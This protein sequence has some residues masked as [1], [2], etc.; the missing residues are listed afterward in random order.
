MKRYT[1]LAAATVLCAAAST[2]TFAGDI[3][4]ATLP[5]NKGESQSVRNCENPGKRLAFQLDLKAN[6]ITAL[7]G[8]MINRPEFK[9]R[10]HARWT[11]GAGFDLK[12]GCADYKGAISNIRSEA[13][14]TPVAK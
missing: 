3:T 6:H 4:P 11:P 2:G 10:G 1:P 12:G 8:I 9:Y 5:D 7:R 14:L 13:G